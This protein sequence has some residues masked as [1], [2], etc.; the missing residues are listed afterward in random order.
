MTTGENPYGFWSYVHADDDAEGGRIIRL[1]E[2]IKAEFELIT[3][4]GRIDIFVDRSDIH[5]GK[6]WRTVIDDALTETAFFIP[7]VTARYIQR[8]ECRRELLLFSANAARRGVPELVLPILYLP[9]PD[10]DESST[11]EVKAI[12]AGTQYESWAD[13]RFEDEDSPSYRR[14]VNRPAARLAQIADEISA[15]PEQG[16]IDAEDAMAALKI[17]SSI[18][19]APEDDAPGILDAMAEA[20]TGFPAWT[21]TM[22]EYQQAIEKIT[23]LLTDYGSK[24]ELAGNTSSGA[25]LLVAKRFAS[26]LD[27][28]ADNFKEIGIRYLDQAK[29]MDGSISVV[30][31]HVGRS[32]IGDSERESFAEF[33]SF[34]REIADSGRESITAVEGFQAG[35]DAV[36]RMSKDIRRPLRKVSQGAQSFLDGQEF[37]DEWVRRLDEIEPGL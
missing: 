27:P 12:L 29:A 35:A 7:I 37:F 20:E 33:G 23:V 34:L 4:G 30:L 15:R 13:L 16:P 19:L 36:G 9:V 17:H 22:G 18:E 21:E 25:K 8:H 1:N 31:S 28:L 11:D 14:A 2:R 3:G 24:M 32:G 26:D 6:K 5:W 10:L